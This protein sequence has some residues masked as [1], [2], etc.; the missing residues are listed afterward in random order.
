VILTVDEDPI[1]G[2]VIFTLFRAVNPDEV[3]SA[4]QDVSES[5]YQ[6]L[7]Q[8]KVS[9]WRIHVQYTNGEI[10]LKDVIEGQRHDDV[11]EVIKSKKLRYE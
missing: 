11:L 5:L 7:R 2:Q 1:F 4:Y 9:G 10:H 3:E 8:N 6:E